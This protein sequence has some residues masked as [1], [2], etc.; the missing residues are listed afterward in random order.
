VE[1]QIYTKS[2]EGGLRQGELIS[3]LTVLSV[4][5]AE[6]TDAA[7]LIAEQITIPLAIV[8]TQDC[9]LDWDFR[10]R[11]CDGEKKPDKEVPWIM[12][13]EVSP[14][15]EIR[16][17]QFVNSGKWRSIKTNKDE[18][19]QF[20]ESVPSSFDLREDG[21]A[22]MCLDFK[23]CFSMV[24]SSVYSQIRCGH[25]NRRTRLTSPYLEHFSSRIFY[26]HSRVGLPAD[27]MSEPEEK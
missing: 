16:G 5:D 1:V 12:F 14:A 3:D 6:T 17:L 2:T 27:H 15:A 23:R 24:T 26:Y 4:F 8:I 9:D 21:L 10:N 7:E 20:F 19:F 13:C 22:E 25:A 18:R 11:S